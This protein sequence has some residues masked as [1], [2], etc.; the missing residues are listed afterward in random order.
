MASLLKGFILGLI[1]GAGAGYLVATSRID[2]RQTIE[3]TNEKAM[4]EKVKNSVKET[5]EE[6]KRLGKRVI[7]DTKEK[8]HKATEA[9]K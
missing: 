6:A 7:E 8:I 2:L 4:E 9:Q 5:T 3:G 1:V